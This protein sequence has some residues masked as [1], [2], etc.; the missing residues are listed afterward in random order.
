MQEANEHDAQDEPGQ[1]LALPTKLLDALDMLALK[2]R[3]YVEARLSGMIPIE[4]GR[5]AGLSSPETTSY[6]YE[7]NPAVRA[8]LQMF[9]RDAMQSLCLTRNDVLMG[10]Q[11]AVNAAATST[12][13]TMAWREIGRVLGAYESEK[14]EVTHK[15]EEATQEQLSRMTDAELLR[16]A[17]SADFRLS[18]EDVIDGEFEDIEPVHTDHE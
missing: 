9:A 17:G 4:A 2:Q 12:E 1:D 13:L 8:V 5:T 6:K 16:N 3:L 11:D 7:K 15:L 14:V 18:D 10:L